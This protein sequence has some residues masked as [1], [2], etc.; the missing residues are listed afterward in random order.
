MGS[1]G[2]ESS[3]LS[4]LS[5]ASFLREIWLAAKGSSA[6]AVHALDRERDRLP[7]LACP[8]HVQQR[9]VMVGR[10]DRQH[11]L[12]P[13]PVRNSEPPRRTGAAVLLFLHHN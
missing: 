13:E 5:C 7:A 3:A 11:S 2:R 4:A 10:G 9:Q 1:R 6:P 8:Y 12:L